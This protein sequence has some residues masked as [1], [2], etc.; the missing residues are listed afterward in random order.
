MLLNCKALHLVDP[1]FGPENLPEFVRI[2]T[3][4]AI[5][6]GVLYDEDSSDFNDRRDEEIEFNKELDA[7]QRPD[8]SVRVWRMIKNYEDQLRAAVGEKKYQELCQ[9][10][11]KVGKP[12]RA[13]LIATEPTLPAPDPLPEILKWF[14]TKPGAG[15]GRASDS[16]LSLR[17]P[18]PVQSEWR[19]R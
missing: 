14:V 3:S 1:H 11:P 17:M 6:V 13:R 4:F 12:T 5:P 7:F 16:I 10:Y 9:K 15:A 8:G 2:A 18:A 19:R